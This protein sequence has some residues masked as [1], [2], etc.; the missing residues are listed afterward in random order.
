MSAELGYCLIKMKNGTKKIR[1]T[2]RALMELEAMGINVM[3]KIMGSAGDPARLYAEFGI[4]EIAKIIWVG[5]KACDAKKLSLNNVVDGLEVNQTSYYVD[6]II[7]EFLRANNMGETESD[8][9]GGDSS[10]PLPGEDE[11]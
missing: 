10:D 11:E 7:S 8:E 2:P 5:R 6:T 9:E 1:Y 4:T 3:S